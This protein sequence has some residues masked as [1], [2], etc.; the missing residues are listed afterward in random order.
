[1]EEGVIRAICVSE[2]K[3]TEK[4]PVDEA[5][6]KQDWGIEG[7]AHAGVWHRQVSLLAKEQI[8][9]FNAEGAQVSFGAFGENLVTEGFDPTSLPL[10]TVIEC[11]NV[12]LM[13]TQ[14]GKECH[15]GCAI[16][17]RM[18]HCIMPQNGVFT[19]VLFGGTLRPGDSLTI[20]R[21]IRVA[22]ICLSDRCSRGEAEDL[23]TP[24]I[25]RICR[26]AGY[27]VVSRL[28]LPDGIEPLASALR[29][30]CDRRQAD[31]VLTSGG[32]GLS[33]RDLTPE[34]TASICERD[35][36]GIAEA[37]R[38]AGM[39]ITPRAMLS[40]ARSVIRAQ[41]LVVNLPGSPKAVEETLP[42]IMPVLDHAVMT[43]K[44]VVGTCVVF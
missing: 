30:L 8:D 25:V 6:V 36:P 39:E 9:A 10:G 13:V 12:V 18:G 35:V 31:L 34:A 5:V 40:R 4:Q 17:Q 32:T 42:V 24:A 28:V 29:Q 11:G 26:D 38:S 2:R 15:S 19:K 20:Y 14:I 22:V 43:M 44:G 7:D 27:P 16:K 3:G 23:S 21:G 41:T 33:P 1:M 37:M